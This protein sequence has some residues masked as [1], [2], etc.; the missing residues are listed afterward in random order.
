MGTWAVGTAW[1]V[2]CEDWDDGD[3]DVDEDMALLVWREEAG[4]PGGRRPLHGRPRPLPGG[5]PPSPV[6]ADLILSGGGHDGI[7]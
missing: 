5:A 1:F 3:G 4:R 7:G 2:G 6:A